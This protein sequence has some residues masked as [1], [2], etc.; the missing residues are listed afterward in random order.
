MSCRMQAVMA[1][2]RK[3]KAKVNHKGRNENET[4]RFAR[5]PHFVL[6]S[7]AYRSLSTNARSLLME[8]ISMDNGENNGKL[9]LSEIDAAHRMGVACPKV[10][11]KAF[12]ELICAGFIAVTKDRHWHIKTGVGRARSWRLT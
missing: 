6:Q 9:W 7:P 5:L 3:P 4:N 8:L 11:H 12:A 2:A 1:N 10:A